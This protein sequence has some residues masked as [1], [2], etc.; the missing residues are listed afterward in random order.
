MSDQ[1]V[2]V[3]TLSESQ[4]E[5][6]IQQLSDKVLGVTKKAL[7]DANLALAPYGLKIEMHISV[8]QIATEEESQSAK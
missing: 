7:A 2:D 1:S 5:S 3:E 4:L 8:Q 6:T